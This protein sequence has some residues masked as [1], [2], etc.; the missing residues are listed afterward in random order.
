MTRRLMPTP[1]ARVLP[2]PPLPPPPYTGVI[3]CQPTALRRL[4]RRDPRRSGE[5]RS[6]QKLSVRVP[7]D[8]AVFLKFAYEDSRTCVLFLKFEFQFDGFRLSVL[9]K[10][11]GLH[12]ISI[13]NVQHL[14]TMPLTLIFILL[15]FRFISL[16]MLILLYNV[17]LLLEYNLIHLYFVLLCMNKAI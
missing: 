17:A 2:L 8:L 9:I 13:E 12:A 1:A 3:S 10:N 6:F 7:E 5:I 11:R 4:S 15:T 16:S 14:N